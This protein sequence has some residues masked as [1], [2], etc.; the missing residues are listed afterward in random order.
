[1]PNITAHTRDLLHQALAEMGT[2]IPRRRLD[3][4][5]QVVISI[6]AGDEAPDMHADPTAREAIRRVLAQMEVAA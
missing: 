1:M 5:V 3:R 4:L 6:W 2:T